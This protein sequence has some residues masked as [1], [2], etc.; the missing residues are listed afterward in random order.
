MVCDLRNFL[1]PSLYRWLASVAAAS[2]GILCFFSLPGI[3]FADN[4][5][6]T[7]KFVDEILAHV[8]DNN[9][10]T[11][12]AK[13]DE[14]GESLQSS[15]DPLDE[16]RKFLR[17]FIAEINIRYGLNLTTHEVCVLVR[18]HIHTLQLPE[19]MQNI[20]MTGIELLE[21]EPT[22][23]YEQQGNFNPISLRISWP[24][25]SWFGLAKN[26]QPIPPASIGIPLQAIHPGGETELPGG[27]YAGGSEIFAGAIVCV[28]GTVFPPAYTLGIGMM[29]DGTRRIL[30]AAEEMEKERLNDPNYNKQSGL[31]NVNF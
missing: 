31:L 20:V 30:N 4:K 12:V 11:L 24:F 2:I 25:E 3:C 15:T 29:V 6:E 22:P 26:P 17:S 14:L 19:E 27:I 18:E 16:G 9:V 28:L 13:F 7:Q 10:D 5:I 21:S 8:A 1:Y 23:I